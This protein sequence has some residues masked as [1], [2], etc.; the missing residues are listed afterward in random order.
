LKK[1]QGR[2]TAEP[3]DPFRINAC[4]AERVTGFR[5]PYSGLFFN[6]FFAE[7]YQC[8][9]PDNA[10]VTGLKKRSETELFQVRLTDGLYGIYTFK[11]AY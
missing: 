5:L 2:Q 11:L 1:Q 8:L 3:R 6:P 4:Y 10:E 9:M 7:K